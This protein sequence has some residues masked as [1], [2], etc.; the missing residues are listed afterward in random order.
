MERKLA[1]IQEI[2]ELTPIEGADTIERASVSG[3]KTVV[4]KDTFKPKDLC[5]FCEVDSILPFAPWSEFLRNKDKPD[6]PIRL[7]SIRLRKTLSQGLAL[8]MSVLEGTGW[9]SLSANIQDFIGQDVTELLKITKYEAPEE[10]AVL[11]GIAKGNFPAFVHK[12]DELRLQSYPK[13]IEEFKAAERCYITLKVDGSSVT[14]YWK[15]QEFGVCSRRL[16]LKEDTTNAFWATSRVMDVQRHLQN[17]CFQLSGEFA[18]QG[19]MVGPGI[20]KNRHKLTEKQIL[21]FNLFNIKE[22]KYCDFELF[23][24]AVET[25]GMS[26]VPIVYN[27]PFIWN[28]VDELVEFANKQTFN[29][30]LAEG[31][32][33]RPE[34]DQYSAVL[35]SRLSIKV[36]SNEYLLKHSI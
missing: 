23:K 8:P 34:R 35:N 3:W 18:L 20:Q 27:G 15:D 22:G 25:S 16:D 2:S 32:V 14:N 24:K 19:E 11:M 36:I 30:E 12:T 4:K 9:H 17:I 26:T 33:I 1:S 29:G 10:G 7:K 13:V 28:T 31:I 21:W 6:K 5:V